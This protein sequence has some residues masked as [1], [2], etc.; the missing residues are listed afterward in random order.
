MLGHINLPKVYGSR[1]QVWPMFCLILKWMIGSIT[2]NVINENMVEKTFINNN[3]F[4]GCLHSRGVVQH[5]HLDL[6][7]NIHL[8][9][10]PRWCDMVLSSWALTFPTLGSLWFS[11]PFLIPS[12]QALMALASHWH[13]S[14]TWA[15]VDNTPIGPWHFLFAFQL[16]LSSSLTAYHCCS[17]WKNSFSVLGIQSPEE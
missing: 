3:T 13:H 6:Q 14:L 5:F 16:I 7:E 10:S 2:H 9:Q 1:S 12:L 8:F 4:L 11:K 17:E 15:Y